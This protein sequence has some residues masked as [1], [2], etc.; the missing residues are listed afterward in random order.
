MGLDVLDVHRKHSV[1][2]GFTIDHG[3][4]KDANVAIG[5]DVFT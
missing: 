1:R 4:A 5:L 3:W 2:E